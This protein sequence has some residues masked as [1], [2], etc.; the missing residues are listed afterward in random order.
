MANYQTLGRV[1]TAFT[2][3]IVITFSV[4]F[5]SFHGDVTGTSTASAWA[6]AP[7]PVAEPCAN[8]EFKLVQR[9]AVPV[10]DVALPSAPSRRWLLSY[11]ARALRRS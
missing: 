5:V 4:C 3:V 2:A 9:V 6:A 11:R 7:A 10:A 8:V 1:A